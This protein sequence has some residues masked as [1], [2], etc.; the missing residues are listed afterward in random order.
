LRTPTANEVGPR[1]ETLST[2]DGDLPRI[3]ERVYRTQANG[4]RVNQTVTLG[5][6]VMFPTP[7]QLI[8]GVAR[9]LD[10]TETAPSKASGSLNPQFVEWLM[11]FP[12]EWTT[13][14]E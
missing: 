10:G 2:K 11:G 13:V 5:L 14:G 1:L 7:T 12:M 8:Q 4:K 6:Q 3:G 9:G